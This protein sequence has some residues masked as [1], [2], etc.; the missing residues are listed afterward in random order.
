MSK[1]EPLLETDESW[2]SLSSVA[3]EKTE[4]DDDVVVKLVENK[5]SL[6]PISLSFENVS[7]SV[8]DRNAKDKNAATELQIIDGITG[9][10]P[11]GRVM[12]IMGPSGAGKTTLL[13]V[14][15]CRKS[16]GT[17][18]GD[19]K[20]NG[21][22]LNEKAFRRISGYVLQQELL[23]GS[24]TVRETLLFAAKLTCPNLSLSEMQDRIEEIL[25]QLHL[26]SCKDTH[27]GNE[28]FRG[29][30]GGEKKR[31][32]IGVELIK[33]PSLLFLDEPTSGLDSFNAFSLVY[34][35]RELAR[36]GRTIIFSIHQPSSEI[37][38]LFD[39]IM[40]VTET[41]KLVTSALLTR[42]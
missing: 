19:I 7:Y 16:T 18:G 37:Y 42:H 39:L 11:S 12:A 10:V 9:H 27:V 24:L 17:V 6:D 20:V 21:S 29:I 8:P 38:T 25:H 26:H 14:L 34:N 4:I 28:F 22:S 35:L 5:S 3:A 40:L 15:A 33:D 2:K 23:L 32:S 1:G 41:G 31:L 30:S 36:S 13:D